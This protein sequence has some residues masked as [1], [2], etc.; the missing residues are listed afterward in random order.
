MGRRNEK[1]LAQSDFRGGINTEPENAQANQVLDA[2]NVWAPRGHIELRPGTYVREFVYY[3]LE[4]TSTQALATWDADGAFVATATANCDTILDAVPVG[5]YVGFLSS[6]R[7]W[8]AFVLAT[9]PGTDNQNVSIIGNAQYWNGTAWVELPGG[10]TEADYD[11]N[12]RFLPAPWSSDDRSFLQ[13]ADMDVADRLTYVWTPQ[14]DMAASVPGVSA[15]YGVRFKITSAAVDVDP[16]LVAYSCTSGYLVRAN[17]G[18]SVKAHAYIDVANQANILVTVQGDDDGLPS[19]VVR[20]AGNVLK[21]S[22]YDYEKLPSVYDVPCITAMPEFNRILITAHNQ[23]KMWVANPSGTPSIADAAVETDPDIVG[24]GTSANPGGILA[25]LD[26]SL[27]A[28]ATEWPKARHWLWFKTVLICGNLEGAPNT[29]QWTA[30][31]ATLQGFRVWPEESFEYFGDDDSSPITGLAS[32][33][34]HVVVFRQDSIWLLVDD[35]VDD[36]GLQRFA[37]AK[38]VDG[39][40]CVSRATIKKIP[41]GLCFLSEDGVYLFNGQSVQ[42][43][44][45]AIDSLLARDMLKSQRFK[46][47][48]DHYKSNNCYLLSVPTGDGTERKT[49]AYDYLNQAWWPWDGLHVMTWAR[50]EDYADEEHMTGILSN[51]MILE[52]SSGKTLDSSTGINAYV[53]T[54]RLGYGDELTKRFSTVHVTAENTSGDLTVTVTPEDVIVG[55]SYTLKTD[56]RETA[57]WGTAIWGA[58]TWPY[59]RRC[60]LRIADRKTGTWATVKV[61]N[62][63]GNKFNIHKIGLG[64]VGL[65]KR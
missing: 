40:G 11:V 42:K 4:G 41:G 38:V 53:Q 59:T 29:V 14:P 31:S 23:T 9:T 19:A 30:A 52:L 36:N 32:F 26:R 60:P 8:L 15:K 58:F 27:I 54:H 48:A 24:G 46:A 50:Y 13:A 61:E 63:D 6:S 18:V 1:V 34:E 65:G 62:E 56:T 22:G 10:I 25:P 35:G 51:G 39:T 45:T 49:Y 21:I 64:A 16:A 17:N 44:S 5:G 20:S 43:I 3:D 28:Q 47:S 37:P 2:L 7:T 12:F 57:L 55:S 33:G